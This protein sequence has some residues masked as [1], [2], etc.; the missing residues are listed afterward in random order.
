MKHKPYIRD[1]VYFKHEVDDNFIYL[2]GRE[3]KS[4]SIRA[5]ALEESDV[6]EVAI[7]HRGVTVRATKEEIKAHREVKTLHGE[8]KYYMPATKWTVVSGDVDWVEKL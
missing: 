8:I 3:G 5:S 1:G 2:K 6:V 7:A 4:I